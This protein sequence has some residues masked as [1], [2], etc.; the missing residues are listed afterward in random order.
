MARSPTLACLALFPC[1]GTLPAQDA[2]EPSPVHG[3]VAV[4]LPSAYVFRGILQEDRELIV[5]PSLELEATLFASEDEA[6]TL[7]S[8]ALSFGQWNS[9]QRGPTGHDAGDSWYEADLYAGLAL[10]LGERFDVALQWARYASPSGAWSAIEE[11]TFAVG[12]DDSELLGEGFAGFQPRVL[13]ARELVGQ[14]DLGV[15]RGTYL[16]LGIEP[17]FALGDEEAAWPITLALPVAV[18]LG[19]DDYY[20]SPADGHDTRL[21]YLDVGLVLAAPIG[22]A[23]SSVEATLGVHVLALGDATRDWNDGESLRVVFAVGVAVAF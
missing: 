1:I 3:A 20:E 7:R 12:Y 19:L 8:L 17:A 11:L 2:Q 23:D 14:S 15:A 13:V 10:G 9:I 5:Q 21:G 6:D 18:G 22:G 16:E 4:D